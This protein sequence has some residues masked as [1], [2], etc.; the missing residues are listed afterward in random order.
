MIRLDTADCTNTLLPGAD[1]LLPVCRRCY[2]ALA[3]STRT[4]RHT[5]VVPISL[6]LSSTQ[7]SDRGACAGA[8]EP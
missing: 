5:T 7:N 2:L 1:E 6:R 4:A 8:I 3:P